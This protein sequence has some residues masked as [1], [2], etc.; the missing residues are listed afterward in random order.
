MVVAEI[1]VLLLVPIG[2]TKRSHHVGLERLQKNESTE[3]ISQRS[4]IGET[5]KVWVCDDLRVD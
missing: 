2:M 5:R 3:W 1:A 4:R